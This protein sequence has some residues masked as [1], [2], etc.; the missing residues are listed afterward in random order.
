MAIPALGLTAESWLD[1]LRVAS[2]SAISRFSK[3]REDDRDLS[4][5]AADWSDILDT[6]ETAEQMGDFAEAGDHAKGKRMDAGLRRL[7]L[8]LQNSA[9]KKLLGDGLSDVKAAREIADRT[10]ADTVIFGHTHFAGNWDIGGG[11]SY[12][13][14]GTWTPLLRI[15]EPE[16]GEAWLAQL[17]SRQHYPVS[18]R[19]SYVKIERDGETTR[20]SL[21]FWEL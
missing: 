5:W 1:R 3:G 16:T 10:G 8:H 11:R 14:S 17:R 4:A 18:N 2:L 20:C 7:I 21:Q 13:N 6:I 12:L 15:P 9:E 19:P